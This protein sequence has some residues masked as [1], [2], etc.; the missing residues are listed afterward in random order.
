MELV[1]LETNSV[2]IISSF[3]LSIHQEKKIKVLFKGKRNQA[4]HVI[5]FKN[6][7]GRSW[8]S[9]D[10]TPWLDS[11]WPALYPSA[12]ASALGAASRRSSPRHQNSPL[13]DLLGKPLK[14]RSSLRPA[15]VVKTPVVV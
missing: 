14:R 13:D 1:A 12:R 8:I 4:V 9:T 6:L 11:S 15:L 7:T 2:S 5:M 3:T 10:P